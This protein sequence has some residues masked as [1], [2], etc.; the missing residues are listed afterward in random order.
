MA[1]QRTGASRE[2]IGASV[3]ADYAARGRRQENLRQSL[4]RAADTEYLNRD[5]TFGEI[6]ADTGLGLLQGATTLGEAA[7]GV[8]NLATFGLL[9]RGLGLADNFDRTNQILEEAKSDQ[10]AYQKAMA[11]QAFEDEG[12]LAGV[13]E[14]VTNPA[15]LGDLAA[16]QIASIL[17][18]AGAGTVAARGVMA[19]AASRNLT[20]A[21]A[22]KLATKKA[23]T[24]ASLTG[25]AQMG[26]NAYVA[27]YNQA[28]D[29][30]LTPD[31]A[32]SRAL[33][34]GYATGA[35]GVGISRLP[36]VGAAGVEGQVAAQVTGA[37]AAGKFGKTLL[38]AG[39]RETTEEYLQSG[40]EALLLNAAS[41]DEDRQLLDGVAK[42]A[43]MGAVGG[44][45]L[46][47]GM[48][49]AP[50]ISGLRSD[51]DAVMKDTA[52]EAGVGEQ[53][54][55]NLAARGEEVLQQE[56]AV[57][58]EVQQQ[59]RNT[60]PLTEADI[61]TMREAD[62]E[63]ALNAAGFTPGDEGR[64]WLMNE[65]QT[66]ATAL[67]REEALQ[68][69]GYV[70][71]DN[72]L[73]GEQ[74]FSPV[75][76]AE[77]APEDTPAP[78]S[79][80][81]Q[82]RL[83]LGD[84]A[85]GYRAYDKAR[86][87]LSEAGVN[88]TV[89][90]GQVRYEVPGDDGPSYITEEQAVSA[91]AQLG[92]ITPVEAQEAVRYAGLLAERQSTP[93]PMPAPRGQEKQTEF[94]SAEEAQAQLDARAE[95]EA[96]EVTLRKNGYHPD[97]KDPDLMWVVEDGEP[98]AYPRA[99]AL[100]RTGYVVPE[101]DLLGPRTYQEQVDE[102]ATPEEAPEL[103]NEGQLAFEGLDPLYA[104]VD[105][106]RR[107]E[108]GV[109]V[110]NDMA[111]RGTGAPLPAPEN[112]TELEAQNQTRQA[113]DSLLDGA[114]ANHNASSTEQINYT[115]G[116]RNSRVIRSFVDDAVEQGIDPSSP[117]AYDYIA[118]R[119]R[120]L[121]AE[122]AK[123]VEVVA[124][125]ADLAH[126][127][128]PGKADLPRWKQAL[129]RKKIAKPGQMRGPVL[130]KFK[131]A[132][133]KATITPGSEEFD[134]FM[135]AF[136]A[137]LTKADAATPFG[138]AIREAYPYVPPKRKAAAAEAAKKGQVAKPAKK[139]T[140]PVSPAVAP[141][142][143]T[144]EESALTEPAP[145]E[146]PLK[147]EK[148]KK[149]NAAKKRTR[150]KMADNR[151][152]VQQLETEVSEKAKRAR[153]PKADDLVDLDEIV[154]PDADPD[155][156]VVER[157]M[158]QA[159]RRRNAAPTE[160][161]SIEAQMEVE[162]IA[163]EAERRV[164]AMAEGLKEEILNLKAAYTDGRTLA[165]E[166][167]SNTWQAAWGSELGERMSKLDVALTKDVPDIASWVALA[168]VV[169]GSP[170]FSKYADAK[171]K[172]N[173]FV[174]PMMQRFAG[175]AVDAPTADAV[176][177]YHA[178]MKQSGIE[179]FIDSELGG[180]FRA[181]A[182]K[183][184]GALKHVMD[185][186]IKRLV[187]DRVNANNVHP[188]K[189]NKSRYSQRPSEAQADAMPRAEIDATVAQFNTNR[190]ENSTPF[191]VFATVAEAQAAIGAPVPSAANGVYYDGKV[192]V[193]AENIS[194]AEML[195][196]VMLH[197][198][199]HAGLEGLLGTERLPAV[200]NR[201]WANPQIR[202]RVQARMQ[203]SGEGR[204]EAAEE[205]LVDMIVSGEKLNKSVFSKIRAAVNRMAQVLFGV[206]DFVMSDA[207]VN[208]LLRDTGDYVRGTRHVLDMQAE[209]A[210]DLEAYMDI[211]EGRAALR[212]PMFSTAEAA[213]E[214]FATEG[215]PSTVAKLQ[216]AYIA[217]RN[218]G[219]SDNLSAAKARAGGQAKSLFQTVSRVAMGFMPLTQTAE[220]HQGLFWRGEPG[221]GVDLLKTF[222]D[223]KIAKENDHNK[224]L[225]DV[226]TTQYKGADGEGPKF[227]DSPMTLA[228]DWQKLADK[229]SDQ[230]DALNVVNQQGTMYKVHPDRT[231][232][233]QSKVDYGRENFTQADRLAAYKQV[234]EQWNKLSPD[235]QNIYRRAQAMYAS[236]WSD[237]M[238]ELQKQAT[239]LAET[240]T[241]LPDPDNPET[242]IGTGQ[243]KAKIDRKRQ[244]VMDRIKEGP[245]SPLAR[246]GD[247]YVVVREV[248]RGN[249]GEIER[250]S[251]VFTSG[252]DTRGGAEAMEASIRERGLDPEKYEVVATQRQQFV[253]E[254]DGMSQQQYTR[255]QNALRGM[256]PE[257][258]ESDTRAR[259]AAMAAME[260]L[261]LQSQPD[262]SI[263]QH[264]NT[265]KGIGGA[266]LD[267][268]RAFTD[269]AL[270][271]A[272]NLSSMRYD[273]KIQGALGEM[274]Q[275][276]KD[277]SESPLLFKRA[278]VLRAVE[279]Q[280]LAS[281]KSDINQLSTAITT[282]GFA[283]LMT[284]PSQIALNVSQT[285]LVTMPFLAARY[286]I[287]TTVK[288]MTEATT[289]YARS[290][291]WGMHSKTGK[292]DPD[293][294]MA[295]AMQMLNSD[296]TL[297]FTQ[298]HDLSDMAQRTNSLVDT[299]LNQALHAGGI[300]MRLSEI[301]NREVSA[302]IAIRGE[303]G[304]AGIT[305]EV[306]AGL[307]E[308]RQ[309]QLLEG[310]ASTARDAVK[311]TQFIYNRSNK[312]A[313][314]QGNFGR[315][316]GQFRQFQTNMLALMYR[317]ARDVIVGI[318]DPSLTP[319]QHVAA[320]Q[321][322]RKQLAYLVTTQL[323]I[324]GTMGSVAAPIVMAMVDAF[325]DDDDLLSA[326]QRY[327]NW[328]PSL[329]AKGLLGQVLD[330]Q[331]FGFNTLV[332]IL[333]SSRYFPTTG[334]PQD[335]LDHVL[336]NALGP[337]YGIA[338][339]WQ[340]G[341]GKVAAGEW[342]EGAADLLPKV[343]ADGLKANVLNVDG[344]KDAQ[345]IVYYQPTG[346]DQFM[347]TLGL[348]TSGQAAMQEDRS[349][350]YSGQQRASVRRSHLIGKWVTAAD[351][352]ER[353][354]YY[355]DI[356]KWNRRYGNDS[357]LKIGMSSLKRAQKTR[358]E[359]ERNAEL[360]GVPST[361]IADTIRR[362]ND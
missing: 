99:E 216:S 125:L 48:G 157:A 140:P 58:R 112:M 330:T 191:T 39:R 160:S 267:S 238:A 328:A 115:K 42:Q 266:N 13:T 1:T 322:A 174:R 355:A 279:Q 285:A 130:A 63:Q 223:D 356:Q 127:S 220:N 258:T 153:A 78:T 189:T 108:V 156:A 299:K 318:Q 18:A 317:S 214:A 16:T 295:K 74:T 194:D 122:P 193:I 161:M 49:T 51:L 6:A 301:Y 184:V 288:Y 315:V 146:A 20:A 89:V 10:L 345:G 353:A 312:G 253:R 167:D 169:M 243:W 77:T 232:E 307:P 64:Y 124:A 198:R 333:G 121:Q 347:N 314:L 264:A 205:V 73:L 286:G 343:F 260:E 35:V 50:A 235:S 273:H 65:D 246:F 256:F 44:G 43:A 151:E 179:A 53:A 332:P 188:Y 197:E 277:G 297:D 296:G 173:Q 111:N 294:A 106:I 336:L 137:K 248:K 335:T 323:A 259:S 276:A 107:K 100:S 311:S 118:E 21:Q 201:L 230:A 24:A 27:A 240:S 29:E 82:R 19:G 213:G 109:A 272:R 139:A 166:E 91:A 165:G 46:G 211:F 351:Y 180:Q 110:L 274:R 207:S 95:L 357:A 262:G 149:I 206:G 23:A 249:N 313:Y 7:Y 306:F 142:I 40:S 204:L 113:W 133:D 302:Y 172:Y 84:D 202:K 209:Y 30:G 222:S 350:I 293:S 176:R 334:D 231:W 148:D 103:E 85:T 138:K 79:S 326:E 33:A 236:L 185:D 66:D 339:Q 70:P 163:V 31:E 208:R 290:K 2:A 150:K 102:P 329:L 241:E 254:L 76:P 116:M 234:R 162:Q 175:L 291:G 346:Y 192:A 303:M 87:I 224:T 9:E 101:N 68:A 98:K 320:T 310:W 57:T 287:G 5:R 178:A 226:R 159:D 247:Y 104:V 360:Y 143:K 252:H 327:L 92:A 90:D 67:T 134:S 164:A 83:D 47:L 11:E 93:A 187:T 228:T 28:I 71:P 132:V 154:D 86:N 141:M 348:K 269:Y 170:E 344:T 62:E 105:P 17:P 354:E 215:N 342:A 34:T 325:G 8:G 275:M 144:G 81:A 41:A 304:K 278:E 268:F 361:R 131:S 135:G 298:T 183:E 56:A 308:A 331:R 199:T 221:A 341:V 158:A 152:A 94:L 309:A 337:A 242:L 292:L 126:A 186:R 88:R 145:P 14:Y 128:D 171:T 255:I 251:V 250:G 217:A 219:L 22:S 119:A 182:A 289:E 54:T 72:D 25:G 280:H 177:I 117:E 114:V 4:Q 305:E 15:L 227:Q 203:R 80:G 257:E 96:Q 321:V 45:L 210:T 263:L 218:E 338:S 12:I 38:D 155:A 282:T 237:R 212:S 59:P 55:S 324:T 233:Q 316:I 358:T 75:A 265:R 349:A 271:S 69:I 181:T 245:Y 283:M 61:L 190:P 37:K 129:A 281:Q 359:K 52:E 3:L 244:I 168:Q 36:G 97:L 239:R 261:Y 284:T 123:A 229:R 225:R 319:E 60:A 196:E 340:R 352:E 195:A 120:A 136:S 26:G 147:T 270:K 362:I 32:N 300:F 200:M